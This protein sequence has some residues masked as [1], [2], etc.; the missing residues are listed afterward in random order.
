[1]YEGTFHNPQK[2]YHKCVTVMK[3]IGDIRGMLA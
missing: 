3:N 2:L 1:M